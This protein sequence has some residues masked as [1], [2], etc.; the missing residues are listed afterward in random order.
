MRKIVLLIV[1]SLCVTLSYAQPKTFKFEGRPLPDWIMGSTPVP[2]DDTYY[3]K[4][5]EG[6]GE[7]MDEARNQAIVKAFQQATA[8]ISTTITTSDIYKAL[9][10]GNSL[11]VISEEF[12][13][14]IYFTC[15]FSKKS[16]DGKSWHYWI[17]CQLAVS[18]NKAPHFDTYFS[19]CNQH[20]IWDQ[21]KYDA[22]HKIKRAE[23]QANGK[24]LLASVFI[25]GAGQMMKKHYLEGSLTLVGEA[26]LLGAGIGTLFAARN[27]AN[28][29]NSYGVDYKTYQS[30]QKSKPVLEGVSYACFGLAAVLYGINLW[31]AY[32]AEPKRRS[33]AF[34]PT[35]IPVENNTNYALGMGA[36][37]KF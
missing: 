20:S 5:F 2:H 9:E 33:Y 29:L 3:Y 34:Y 22:E 31:R 1:L 4:V 17:L 24:A 11:N 16:F 15:E 21:K 28:I 18:G 12:T 30:A 8:F 7:D 35:I 13:I 26:A 6:M 37:I 36:S 32:A 14:P 25:P 27:K 10:K 19:D 23:N